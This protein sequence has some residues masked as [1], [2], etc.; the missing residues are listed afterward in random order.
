VITAPAVRAW[1]INDLDEAMDGAGKVG[2][3]GGKRMERDA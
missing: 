1:V 2:V 3:D